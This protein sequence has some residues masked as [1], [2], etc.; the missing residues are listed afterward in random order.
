M[1]NLFKTLFFVIVASL[2]LA[3]FMPMGDDNAMSKYRPF[4]YPMP[5]HEGDTIAMFC[6]AGSMSDIH[7][8]D[9]AEDT[10]RSW[11]FNTVRSEMIGSESFHGFAGSTEDRRAEL[12][13]YLQDPSIKCLFAVR[14]GW[15]SMLQTMDIPLDSIRKYPKW[16]IGFSDVTAMHS[17]WFAAGVLSIHGPMAGQIAPKIPA[18]RRYGKGRGRRVIKAPVE[19]ADTVSAFLLRSM[20]K[21]SLPVVV[22]DTHE[23]AFPYNHT[24]HAEG[25]LV[26]GNLA[27]LMPYMLTPWDVFAQ[28]EDIILFLEDVGSGI[29]QMERKI[30]FMKMHGLLDKVKGIICGYFTDVAPDYYDSTEEMLE[31]YFSKLNVPVVYHFP[32]GHQLPNTPLLHGAKVILDVQDTCVSLQYLPNSISPEGR[33]INDG[34]NP[35]IQ[36]AE[37]K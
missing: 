32:A 24:G 30:V 4:I 26:G 33:F 29:R 8:V 2:M 25:R 10:L 22:R 9:R 16:L 36:T 34:K 31:K 13:S 18:P 6:P 12:L 7:T 11:G 35:F 28:N 27:T 37:T 21:G 23:Q 15:G 5:L 14:G 3:S 1:N 17:A 20:M 19:K